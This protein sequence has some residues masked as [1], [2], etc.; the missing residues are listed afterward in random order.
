MLIKAIRHSA[1]WTEQAAETCIHGSSSVIHPLMSTRTTEPSFPPS[2]GQVKKTA[3]FPPSHG[4]GLQAPLGGHGLCVLTSPAMGWP[5]KLLWLSRDSLVPA[6]QAV[7]ASKGQQINDDFMGPEW[8]SMSSPLL[9]VTMAGAVHGKHQGRP[10]FHTLTWNALITF[11]NEW[12]LFINLQSVS[13]AVI[14]ETAW[15]SQHSPWIILVFRIFSD[16]DSA[17]KCLSWLKVKHM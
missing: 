10:T 2:W 16:F 7:T 13:L 4:P 15:E 8:P 14:G 9:P 11:D 3:G 17:T 12:T 1:G 6:W 5:E